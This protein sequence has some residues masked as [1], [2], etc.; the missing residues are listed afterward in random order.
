MAIE[1][2]FV[3]LSTVMLFHCLLYWFGLNMDKYLQWILGLFIVL[4]W[5]IMFKLLWILIPLNLSLAYLLFYN[6]YYKFE[7]EVSDKL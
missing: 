3:G 6:N 1:L 2:L 7:G 4:F 5:I